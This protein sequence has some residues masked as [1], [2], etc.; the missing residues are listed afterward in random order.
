MDVHEKP[1]VTGDRKHAS[2]WVNQVRRETPG[3]EYGLNVG[4][5]IL[6]IDDYRV[7]A[8]RWKDRLTRY[9]PKDEATL[10]IA[11]RDKLMRIDVVFGEEPAKVWNL[12]V[13]PDATEEQKS[14]LE[15][16]LASSY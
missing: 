12:E 1:P 7:S 9:R 3:Y 14:R 6:A 13:D 8:D 16:W 5:E 15:S 4:D 10:L 2:V 11:R